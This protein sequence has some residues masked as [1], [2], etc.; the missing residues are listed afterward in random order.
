[1][2]AGATP[3]LNISDNESNS[4]PTYDVPL[5]NLAILPSKPS[6]NAANIIAMIA[7]WN[8]P[9]NANLIEVKPMQTPINVSMFG[10]SILAF[11]FSVTNLKLF[12]GCSIFYF[13]ANKV[14]PEIAV[15][16]IFTSGS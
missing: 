12:F 13:F 8:S 14:S 16:P 5:I 9:L 3:K 4:F 2:N 7:K 1:M 10:R 15:W 6:I 11:F